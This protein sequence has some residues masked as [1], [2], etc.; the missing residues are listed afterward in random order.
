MV[1]IYN[2]L[3]PLA[4]GITGQD[5]VRIK[6]PRWSAAKVTLMV[7][8]NLASKNSTMF[9]MWPLHSAETEKAL[10]GPLLASVRPRYGT[11]QY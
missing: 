9:F 5:G 4:S 6:A 11:I 1:S 7:F 10:P 2:S 3:S 8:L